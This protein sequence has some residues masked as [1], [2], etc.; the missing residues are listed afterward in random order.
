M[1]GIE[2]SAAVATRFDK[3]AVRYEATVHITAIND[4]LHSLRNTALAA[5]PPGWWR[6]DA[7]GQ[8][9]HALVSGLSAASAGPAPGHS[10]A[11]WCPAE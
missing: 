4:W 1:Q 5:S 6:S 2:G 11:G 10:L 9:D 8:G 7:A 3:L